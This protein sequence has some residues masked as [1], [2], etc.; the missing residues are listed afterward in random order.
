MGYGR[1][2]PWYSWLGLPS[3]PLRQLVSA[4]CTRW[5]CGRR[6][7]LVTKAHWRRVCD[8]VLYKLTTFTFTY[9]RVYDC[10]HITEVVH[11]CIR[12]ELSSLSDAASADE[13]SLPGMSCP[14]VLGMWQNIMVQQLCAFCYSWP[15]IFSVWLHEWVKLHAGK[16]LPNRETFSSSSRYGFCLHVNLH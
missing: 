7:W 1:W 13:S 15:L 12:S 2:G 10:V 3:Q 4:G 16:F 14:C 9:N 5:P 6:L 11:F 8:D